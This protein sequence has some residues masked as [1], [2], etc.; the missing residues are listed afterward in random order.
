MC[1]IPRHDVTRTDK[2]QPTQQTWDIG[3][4]NGR[5]GKESQRQTEKV[6]MTLLP[7]YLIRDKMICLRNFENGTTGEYYQNARL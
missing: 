3:H 5:I 7:I 2:D 6:T 1:S 4:R